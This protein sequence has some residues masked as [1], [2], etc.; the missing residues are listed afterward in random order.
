M[1]LL[2]IVF[3]VD[4]FCYFKFNN[5]IP[6][7]RKKENS[8]RLNFALWDI[9]QYSKK[10]T[11]NILIGDSRMANMN[12]EVIKSIS[13]KD[14]FL[15]SFGG[16]NLQ[17]IISTYQYVTKLNKIESIYIGVNLELYN[18]TNNRNRVSGATAILQNP[19][20]YL[21]NL[22]VWQAT[23]KTLASYFKKNIKSIGNPEMSKEK[24]WIHQV[25]E[26]GQRNLANYIYPDNYHKELTEIGKYCKKQGIDFKIIVFPTHTDIQQLFI[27]YHLL[28]ENYKFLT[29]LSEITEVFDLNFPNRITKDQ[30]L[31]S[32]PYHI[33]RDYFATQYIPLLLNKPLIQSYSIIR[34]YKRDSHI[35]HTNFQE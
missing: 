34:V 9:I 17:E 23:Y 22:N 32:D 21:I 26:T 24:F 2:L 30:Q 33:K 1:L 31:F 13:G 5:L 7:E 27:K 15:F 19:L 29:D 4:P 8:R 18:K 25:N 12:T 3:L 11:R 28:E 20:L 16:G 10:P 35:Q 6:E 14:F